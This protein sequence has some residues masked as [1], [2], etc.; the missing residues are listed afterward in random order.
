[1]DVVAIV[2]LARSVE[3]EAPW[4]ASE[5]GST[6]Y[7]TAMTLR[8]ASPIIVY[9]G[10]D[11]ARTTDLLGKLRARGHDAIACELEAVRS[12]D[13]MFRPKAFRFEG[14]DLIGVGSREE[15]RLPLAD[16]VALVR[17]NHVTHTE[18]TVV[19]RSRSLS[20][21]RVA[22][23]G[24][25][26]ATK[27]TRKETRR[28]SEEREAVVYMFGSDG[29]PWLLAS[30]QLR[31]DGLGEALRISKTENFEVLLGRLRELA[32]SAAYDTRLLAVR[33]NATVTSTSATHLATS[34]ATALDLLAH[35]VALWHRRATRPYR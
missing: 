9:R 7:E 26:V 29:D 27:T 1:M 22:L 23:T 17:A 6:A 5:L 30:T 16:V 19:E 35:L 18:D 34:S 13:D 33:A 20:L 12:S 28:V 25:M 3:E 14:R 4:L 11:R 32:P 31:Y 8:G 15:R 24:G 2:A 21:G 10:G